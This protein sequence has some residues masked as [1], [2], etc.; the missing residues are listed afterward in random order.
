MTYTS[1]FPIINVTVD[2]VVTYTDAVTDY[3]W[4][5]VI[6][7]KN[8][9]FKGQYALP[10]GFLNPDEDGVTAAL[11]ELEEETGIYTDHFIAPLP[12]KT[13]PGRDPR[14]AVVSLPYLFTV[15]ERYT[16]K[17]GDDAAS[18]EWVLLHELIDT[19]PLA[20]DHKQILQNA[21][22]YL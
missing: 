2:A 1:E 19:H 10:G 20:F 3:T 7:R 11:R 15:N 12:P 6:R 5:L 22:R 4:A 17:A 14:G 13:I 8:E 16:P 9:P 21:M 18:A